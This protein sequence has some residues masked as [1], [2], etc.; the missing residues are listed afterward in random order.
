MSHRVNQEI[1]VL[2][3][4][5]GTLTRTDTCRGFLQ[6]RMR[7]SVCCVLLLGCMFPVLVLSWRVPRWRPRLTSLALWL[8]T[9]QRSPRAIARLLRAYGSTLSTHTILRPEMTAR[10]YW[11]VRQG[12]R[13][14]VVSASCSSWIRPILDAAGLTGVRIVTSRFGFWRGGL[15]MR[16]RCAG[17][18][19]VQRLTHYQSSRWEYAYTDSAT[20]LPMLALAHQPTLVGAGRLGAWW[21]KRH[22]K[23]VRILGG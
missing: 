11:H 21:I 18:T 1:G 6:Y 23:T 7:H 10:L 8:V 9:A 4:F 5:D 13:V 20:D 12:H 22:L 15:V 16:E 19:K 3:D 17:V 2:V 14:V